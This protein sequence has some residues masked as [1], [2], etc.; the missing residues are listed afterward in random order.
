MSDRWGILLGATL[1]LGLSATARALP[2]DIDMA[3]STTVKA[4]EAVMLPPPEGAV[5]QPSM[6]SPM[7]FRPNFLRGSP[8]GEALHAPF[9]ATADSV[10][11]G[12]K[13]YDI[14]C[15]P[16]HGDGAKLGPVAQPGR[17]PGVVAI[18]GPGG[19]AA[20]VSDGWLYLTIR[21][22]SAIMMPYAWAMNDEEIWS[23]VQYIR[24]MPGAAHVAP[25]PAEAP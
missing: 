8:E 9:D 11:H 19:R 2:W 16:C 21:N 15:L 22:G 4:Y 3:D 1:A 17:F 5:A 7:S 23:V 14:Y 10:A 13:M 18:S 20:S 24:T 6:Y 25:V 12:K